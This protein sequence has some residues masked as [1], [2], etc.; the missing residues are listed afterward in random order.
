MKS[1]RRKVLKVFARE[2]LRFLITFEEDSTFRGKFEKKLQENETR[3]RK[4]YKIY[5]KLF[6]AFVAFL[7][8][9]HWSKV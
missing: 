6:L 5:A 7:T 8:V 2:T 4:L 1:S 3:E 9:R